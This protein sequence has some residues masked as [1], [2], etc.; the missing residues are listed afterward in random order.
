[1]KH[2]NYEFL[3]AVANGEDLSEWEFKLDTQKNWSSAANHGEVASIKAYKFR[4][5][6][7]TITING[8]E[9]PEPMRV[10]P[11]CGTFY[12]FISP[13]F[14]VSEA[15]WVNDTN[16]RKFLSIGIC[17]KT[18]EAAEQHRRALILASGGNPYYKDE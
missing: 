16:D 5:K 17:H 10:A 1:M 8:I 7:K 6:Q 4:R 11:Q 2:Q 9:V 13:V 18:R 3:I 15:A 12:W 14:G